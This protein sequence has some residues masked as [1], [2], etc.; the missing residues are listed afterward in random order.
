MQGRLLHVILIGFLP[1][2]VLAQVGNSCDNPIQICKYGTQTVDI[3]S[4]VTVVSNIAD[5]SCLTSI[6]S[7]TESSIWLKYDFE[8]AGN[9]GF[10]LTPETY[11]VDLDF[12]VFISLT[13][14]C[15]DMISIRCM[16]SGETVGF[17]NSNSRCMGA[18]GLSMRS[19]DLLEL[20][21]CQFRDDNFLAA[22]QVTPKP[23][24][25]VLVN[26]FTG[27]TQFDVQSYGTAEIVCETESVE[28]MDVVTMQIYPNPAT[29]YINITIDGLRHDELSYSLV[30]SEGKIIRNNALKDA[31]NISVVDVLS[32][33]YLINIYESND[34][35]Y[36]KKVLVIH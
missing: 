28:N 7:F 31:N 3:S 11:D 2:L 36:S 35:L 23:T 17:G 30:D 32:G 33:V 25:F 34:L 19:H 6:M 16:Q 29:S 24:F 26:S 12:E 20:A 18:T 21:G 15:D 14:D 5:Q 9:F 10:T 1:A 4:I 8:T 22:L 13:D 27:M